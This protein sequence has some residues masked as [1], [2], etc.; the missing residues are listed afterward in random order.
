MPEVPDAPDIPVAALAFDAAAL[1]YER[2]RPTYPP[3]ALDVL[4]AEVGVG[5]GVRV[6]DLAA[7]TGKLTRLLA[8]TGADVVAV[9]PLPRMR[10][11]LVAACPGV[12]ALDGTAEA[13]PLGDRTVEVVTVA[14]AFHWFRPEEALAEITRV[15]VPGGRL[16][17]VFNDRDARTGWVAAWNDAMAWHL[18][19]ASWYHRDEWTDLLVGAGF[20]DLGD[21]HVEWAEPMTR[22]VLA[23]RVRSVS[24][25]AR[26]PASEQQE[27]VERILALTDGFDEPF[28][29][30]YVTHL[31]WASTPTS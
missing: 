7:G 12:E 4:R 21:A 17:V 26:L 5:P 31:W 14:Q 25:V 13:I 16:A 1:D 18:T 6:L 29:L 22:D 10:E 30:P 9:E 27:F 2:S 23:S 28:D 19:R 11:Q 8:A 24:Y 20:V 15:L 3:A